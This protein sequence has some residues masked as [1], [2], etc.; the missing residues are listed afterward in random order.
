MLKAK[1]Q[2]IQEFR[3][4]KD[5]IPSTATSKNTDMALLTLSAV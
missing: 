1:L 4:E 3:E 2:E 5:K